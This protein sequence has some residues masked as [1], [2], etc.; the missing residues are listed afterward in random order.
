MNIPQD[1]DSR[2]ISTISPEI[3][4]SIQK[5]VK[6][7]EF[8]GVIIYNCPVKIAMMLAESIK[9]I[10]ERENN[11]RFSKRLEWRVII[12]TEVNL[13]REI[14]KKHEY[15]RIIIDGTSEKVET[16][17]NKGYFL[18]DYE[19]TKDYISHQ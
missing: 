6:D 15:F 2:V 10:K 8:G 4:K 9:T 5:R 12:K 13:E 18:L 17:K 1:E 3:L 14:N 16:Q 19:L 11:S 7:P